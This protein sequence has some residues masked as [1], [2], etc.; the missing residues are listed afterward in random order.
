MKSQDEDR[1]QI[2]KT[3]SLAMINL[4]ELAI[5]EGYDLSTVKKLALIYV[6]ALAELA[7]L[8]IRMRR[9]PQGR[10]SFATFCHSTKENAKKT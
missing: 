9:H 1:Q 2:M 7:Y 5:S 10:Q 3:V 4:L 6:H 8:D